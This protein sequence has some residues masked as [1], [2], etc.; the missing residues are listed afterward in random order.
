MLVIRL[1]RHG[2]KNHPTYRV[3][4]Q[5]KE[6]SPTSKVLETLG[7]LDTNSE[8]RTIRLKNDR[9]QYWLNHGAQASSVVHNMLVDQEVVTGPKRRTIFA[10]K[11]E[12]KKQ[13]GKEAAPKEAPAEMQKQ[14][15]ETAKAEEPTQTKK[16]KEEGAVPS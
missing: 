4:L 6:W 7:Y 14:E 16:E 10:K 13:Q 2:R 9:I 8:P 11:K 3:V 15:V 5:E 1:S 12:E